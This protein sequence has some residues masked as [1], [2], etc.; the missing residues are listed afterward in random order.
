MPEELRYCKQEQISFTRSRR[1]RKNANCFVEQKNYSIVRR[2]IGYTRYD[3][4]EQCQLLNGLY[5]YLRLYTNFFCP[6]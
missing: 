6:R 1:Y 3:T 5:S 2:A 4:E